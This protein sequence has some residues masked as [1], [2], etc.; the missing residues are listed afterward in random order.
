MLHVHLS[1]S[2]FVQRKTRKSPAPPQ[3]LQGNCPATR[4]S[5]VPA[6]SEELCG[7]TWR[8]TSVLH[9][10]EDGSYS[11]LLGRKNEREFELVGSDSPCRATSWFVLRGARLDLRSA[12]VRQGLRRCEG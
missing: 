1:L 7:S 12:G 9:Y 6:S 10:D 2:T 4:G 11:K 5:G 8:T 3:A